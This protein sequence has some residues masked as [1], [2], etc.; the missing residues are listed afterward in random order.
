MDLLGFPVNDP[1]GFVTLLAEWVGIGVV[2]GI[3]ASV[4]TLIA[5]VAR[6]GD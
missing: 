1:S 2:V 3:L 5:G 6:G 4:L